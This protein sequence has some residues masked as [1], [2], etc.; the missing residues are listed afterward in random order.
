MGSDWHI[1]GIHQEC[2]LL[3]MCRLQ[4]L[5]VVGEDARQEGGDKVCSR[6][7]GLVFIM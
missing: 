5:G 3:E 2:V 1:G 4:G 7:K 6:Q